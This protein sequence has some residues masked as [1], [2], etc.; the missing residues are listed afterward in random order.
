MN[1]Y[2]IGY[3]GCGKTTVAPLIAKALGW[4]TRDSD[5]QIELLTN[6]TITE[7]FADDGETIF[8]EWETTV[9]QAL[10]VESDKVV[11]VGGGAPISETNRKIMKSSGCA[12][13]LQAS[14]D[15]LWRRIS[16]DPKSESMRPKLTDNTDGIQEVRQVLATRRDAY[17]NCAD[18][19]IQTE[20]LSP[21]EVADQIAN[22]WDPVDTH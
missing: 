11:S 19:M 15:E 16:A 2:L 1:L 22:W 3:R 10:A 5:S 14:A 21:G 9:L 12:V 8:R 4:E 18:Y 17:R 6:R 13:W 20:G 7:I